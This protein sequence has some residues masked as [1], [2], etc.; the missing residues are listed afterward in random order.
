MMHILVHYHLR[1]G[2]VTQ[3][4]Q[5]QS[6]SFEELNY[7]H[8]VLSSEKASFC[9]NAA[10]VPALDYQSPTAENLHLDL[11]LQAIENCSQPRI[12][13]LHNPTLG[14]HP[15]MTQF[16]RELVDRGE[17][18]IM[19]LHDFAE[20]QRPKNLLQLHQQGLPWFPYSPRTHYLVL[21]E[22]DRNILCE[23]GL[24]PEQATILI[25]PIDPSPL[26]ASTRRTPYVFYPTR[27]ITRKNM[28]ELLLLAQLAPSETKF[29]TSQGPGSSRYQEEYD[30]WRNLAHAWQLPIDWAVTEQPH[31]GVDFRQVQQQATHLVTTSQQEGFGM[32]F[33]EAVAWQRPLLGRRIAHVTADLRS[34]NVD[35]PFL[36]DEILIDG[37]PFSCASLTEK[38]RLLKRARNA[39]H[40]VEIINHHQRIDARQWLAETLSLDQ[41]PLPISTIAP[42]HPDR[43]AQ[44]ILSI[45]EK[46]QHASLGPVLD[47]DLARIARGFAS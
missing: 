46:L 37:Q 13:H 12:W 6:R 38:T 43:H 18:V 47:L 8:V 36:Y 25:N 27:A 28:G 22:R 40:G 32:I 44:T 5:Q 20:D 16:V 26:A 33:L 17:R 19:Q 23:A 35:H 34:H 7:D 9:R 39:P 3:V 2:G 4:L 14:C 21:T 24:P 31:G 45:A 29:A 10:C 11:C 30:H 42:F 15:R 1:S 41:A